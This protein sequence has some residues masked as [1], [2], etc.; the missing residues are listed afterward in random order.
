MSEAATKPATL[1]AK[2]VARLLGVS[3]R[4]VYRSKH[5]P[6]FP[7]PLKGIGRSLRWSRNAFEAY[8]N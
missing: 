3:E 4:T 2:E 5:D 6:K 1:T 7:K 8:L